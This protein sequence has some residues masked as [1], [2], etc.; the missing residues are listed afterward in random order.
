MSTQ[1]ARVILKEITL[2]EIDGYMQVLSS[3][4]PIANINGSFCGDGCGGTDGWFCGWNCWSFRAGPGR[5][6]PNG[7]SG[8]TKKDLD[9]A[10]KDPVAF[11]RVLSQEIAATAKAL[12]AGNP[13]LAPKVDI[14]HFIKG[15]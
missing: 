10:I 8:L 2:A 11:R 5:I 7:L 6:D 15:S 3:G 12:A 13:Y 9:A 4:V 1:L 14:E